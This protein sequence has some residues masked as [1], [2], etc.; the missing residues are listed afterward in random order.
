MRTFARYREALDFI[1]GLSNIPS[2]GD[3][4][5][6]QHDPSVY[7]KRIKYFLDLIGNPEKNFK[8]I[9]VAGTAGKGTVTNMLHEILF[10]SGKKVGSFSS[11]PV[12]SAI[13]RI[14]VNEFYISPDRFADIVDGLKPQIDKAYDEGPFGGP[15]AFEIFLAI[16]FIYFR[17][18]KCEWVVLEVG[19]GGRYDATNIISAPKITAVTSIDYDHTELLGKT[20]SKIAND[21]AGIIKSRSEFFTAEERSP[22]IGIFKRICA[23]QGAAFHQI[24]RQSD[25]HGRNEALATAIAKKIGIAEKHV[26]RGLRQ[27]R[28]P[29]RFEIMEQEPL[30]ILDGAHNRSKIKATLGDLKKFPFRKLFLIIGIAEN[31]DHVSILKEIAPRADVILITRYQNKDRKCAAPKKLAEKARAFLKNGARVRTYLDPNQALCEARQKAR[32]NDMILITGSFFL[33]GE[34]RRHWRSEEKIL[35]LRKSF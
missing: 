27:S 3:Y 33:A 29:C 21:K 12:V 17:Q 5:V 1:E 14:R 6:D 30:I 8:Y 2:N 35:K 4:L 11:P 24:P 26:V 20:L 32:P 15:S 9:H 31:K 18:K 13:E 10:A 7:L 19:L 34:M 28:L 16:A 22:V 23:E 25:Y